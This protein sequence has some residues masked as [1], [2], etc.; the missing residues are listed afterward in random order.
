MTTLIWLLNFFP[1]H[2]FQDEL[3]GPPT[4]PQGLR[5]CSDL[6]NFL[7]RRIRALQN[8]FRCDIRTL[9]PAER[10]SKAWQWK[11]CVN[12]DKIPPE[13][14]A[15]I[16]ECRTRAQDQLFTIE[17]CKFSLFSLFHKKRYSFAAL[18]TVEF[19]DYRRI[20]I[21]SIISQFLSCIL[22]Q[23]DR[24]W[25]SSHM[26]TSDFNLNHITAANTHLRHE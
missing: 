21:I 9:P 6:S 2:D 11:Y 15:A 4:A 24:L 26:Y 10:E 20:F 7:P 8:S 5:T 17:K 16:F 19:W 12:N 25:F 1:G 13:K 22:S 18:D 23:R 3:E 14:S